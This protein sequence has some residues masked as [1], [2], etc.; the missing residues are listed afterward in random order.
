MGRISCRLNS[1]DSPRSRVMSSSSTVAM[2]KR[3]VLKVS[4]DRLWRANL[5]MVKLRP[6]MITTDKM[7]R[8]VLVT[9]R[10][11]ADDV[12]EVKRRV[13]VKRDA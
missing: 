5:T 3:N 4:G 10:V 11:E 6:Q 9:R 7:M 13:S 8:S 2:L 12:V 1:N